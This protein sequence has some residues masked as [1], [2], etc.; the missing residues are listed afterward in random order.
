MLY[1]KI[2]PKAFSVLEKKIL[3]VFAISWHGGN[4]DLRI[5][6]ICTNF[7][8]AFNRMLY[9][10]F[11]EIRTPGGFRGGSKLDRQMGG[12][13]TVSDHNGSS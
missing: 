12:Q 11:E 9:M 2:Q 1:T 6:T 4:L 3:S 13:W 7:K 10:K 8:S 5:M